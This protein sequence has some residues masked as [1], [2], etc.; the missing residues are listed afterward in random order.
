M[1]DA[2]ASGEKVSVACKLEESLREAAVS[3]PKHRVRLYLYRNRWGGFCCI[4]D[5]GLG[6]RPHWEDA[7][8]VVAE[9]GNLVAEVVVSE[10][11][12]ACCGQKRGGFS[13][14]YGEWPPMQSASWGVLCLVNIVLARLSGCHSAET[15]LVNLVDLKGSGRGTSD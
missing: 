5:S 8:P 13:S 7:G 12:V 14:W 4:H 6:T 15:R 10:G 9:V 1:L 2:D 3:G 11:R